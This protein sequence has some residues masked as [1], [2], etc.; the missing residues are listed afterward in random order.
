MNLHCLKF[1]YSQ[2]LNVSETIPSLVVFEIDSNPFHITY[3][4][5]DTNFVETLF[6]N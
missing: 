1:S 4:V 3:G 6:G 5:A 2:S